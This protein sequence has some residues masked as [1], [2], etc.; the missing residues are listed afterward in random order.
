MLSQPAASL[1]DLALGLV[2]LGLALSLR[3]QEVDRPWRRTLWWAAA[4][5]L[6][7]A[8]HHGYVT[9]SERWAG[10]SWAVISG[11]VVITISCVLAASVR[12]VLGP[13]RRNVFW[14][15]RSTSL[16]AYAVLAV[17]GYYGVGTMLACEGLT[18][19]MIL[20]LWGVAL[21]RG[22]VRAPAMLLALGASVLAGCVRALP[23]DVTQ[24]VGLDPTSLYHLAQI[25]GMV[26]LYMA[27]R[28]APAVEADRTWAR[29]ASLR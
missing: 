4:A 25:P 8:V 20:A 10:P 17:L 15:L 6:A 21:R 27:L 19:I 23:G 18:M 14:V 28:A 22:H 7:G 9:Y 29:L 11:M 1:T 26:L 24:T 13:G 16:G 5:A 3:G 12:D 2:V